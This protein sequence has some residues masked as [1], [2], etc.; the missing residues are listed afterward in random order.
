M[1]L[2]SEAPAHP[3]PPI[4]NVPSLITCKVETELDSTQSYYHYYI[5]L[6][7]INKYRSES[8]P[9]T[10]NQSQAYVFGGGTTA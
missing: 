5:S 1:T 7:N 10:F 4:N 3:P 6:P 9:H 8:A 2:P